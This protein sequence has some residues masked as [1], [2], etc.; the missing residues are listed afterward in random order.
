MKKNMGNIDRLIRSILALNI[1][2]FFSRGF[3][4]GIAA[5]ILLVLAG[6]FLV[7]SLFAN[8]PLYTLLG[9][10]TNKL[11]DNNI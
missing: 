6:A 11:R 10:H 9:I 8:C 1:I 2:F 5:V 7:T 4:S 3:I